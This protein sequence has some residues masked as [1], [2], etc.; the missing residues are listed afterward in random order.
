M[1]IK[2]G[3]I[4]II[5]ALL[6][7]VAG[8]AERS[9]KW[10]EDVLLPDGRIVA[11]TRY[12]EF[13]GPYEIGDTP[14]E[15][16]YWFEFK[17]PDTGETVRWAY[18]R[19]LGTVALLVHDKIPYLLLAPRF[20][21]S[22]REFNCPDPSYILFAYE[23]QHWLRRDL[24]AMPVPRLRSNMTYNARDQRQQIE[25][26]ARHLPVEVTRA[27]KYQYRPW[28]MDFATAP[29]QTFGTDNCYRKASKLLVE[30]H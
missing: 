18:G 1:M 15:S 4:A 26:H 24:K 10:Q 21:D 5:S 13:K 11:L 23:N 22:L 8:C 3:L 30:E 19:H 16:D 29:A 6:L 9:L 2:S 14:T 27:S 20:G 12:Q 25:A 17:H 7:A 28:L